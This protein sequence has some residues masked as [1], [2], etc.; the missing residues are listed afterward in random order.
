MSTPSRNRSSIMGSEES[1]LQVQALLHETRRLREENEVLRIQVNTM[2]PHDGQEVQPKERPL[3]TYYA[4]LDENSDSTHISAKRR[5]DRRSQNQMQ[6]V[7]GLD[8]LRSFRLFNRRLD[9]MLSTPFSPCIINY[10]PPKGFMVP[11]F[12]TYNG[13]SDPFDRIMHYR[14]LITLDIRNNTLLCKVFPV[15]LHGQTLS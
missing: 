4:P 14:Q 7:Q 11:K 1:E 12:S 13:T 8:K 9:D 2:V 5:R 3:P 6:C 15:S 10:E